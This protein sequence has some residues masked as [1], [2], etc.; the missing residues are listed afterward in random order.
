[1]AIA[2]QSSA[3]GRIC[4]ALPVILTSHTVILK[5]VR[6]SCEN[7]GTGR[8]NWRLDEMQEAVWQ[9]AHPVGAAGNFGGKRAKPARQQVKRSADPTGTTVQNQ[10]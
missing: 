3:A 8:Q 4:A 1:M 9:G 10:D 5:S 7:L 6:I 2:V